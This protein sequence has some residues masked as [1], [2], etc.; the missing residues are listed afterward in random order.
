MCYVS[1]AKTAVSYLLAGIAG[2][3]FLAATPVS[4]LEASGG[5]QVQVMI[6]PPHGSSQLIVTLP[7][8]DSK[9]NEPEVV[10]EGEV[11][12]ISQID[13]FIDGVYNNTVALGYATTAFRSTVTVP[14]GTHTIKLV[15][16]DN[17][18][19]ATYSESVVVTYEPRTLPSA[20]SQTN[21]NIPSLN[22]NKPKVAT[23]NLSIIA[24]LRD[25]FTP[26]PV[27]SSQ[28]VPPNSRHGVGQSGNI[29]TGA[30]LASQTADTYLRAA[31]AAVGASLLVAYPSFQ[32]AGEYANRLLVAHK[33][34]PLHIA[35][36]GLRTRRIEILAG[37]ALL[38]L[39]FFL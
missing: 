16:I 22:E 9:T 5:S 33:H 37:L 36:R 29:D 4:A 39:P 18:S 8:S 38:L 7:E 25:I 17:C 3:A 12:Y 1:G 27:D 34:P 21:T 23:E 24:L 26:Q 31:S 11:S 28:G 30:L 19:Q 14:A 32:L 35:P 15:A 6:C 2:I 20:G 10:I 13:F